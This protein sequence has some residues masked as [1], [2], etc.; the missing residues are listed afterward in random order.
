MS[1]RMVLGWVLVVLWGT[2]VRA[3]VPISRDLLPTRTALARVGLERH[4]MGMVPMEPT[5]RLLEISIADNLLFAQTDHANFYTFDAESGRLL[6][7]ARLGRQSGDAM[8]A[9]VNSRMVFVTNANLLYALDRATGRPV[10]VENLNL[11]ATSPTAC[12]EERVIVGLSTG[13]LRAFS[14]YE[15]D[16]KGLLVKDRAGRPVTA[17]QATFAWNWQTIGTMRSRP[18]PAGRLVVFGGHD[19]RAY[20][21]LADQAT[22]VYR[23]ATGGEI[24]APIS[25]YKT[26]TFLIPSAD[27]NVYSIDLFTAQVNWVFSTGA[28]V[29]QEPLVVDNDAYIV[30]AA[31]V[32]FAMDIPTGKSRWSTT[33]HG[34]RLVSVSGTRIYLETQD[35][36]LFIVDRGTGKMLADP[37]TTYTRAGLNLRPFEVE[38]TNSLNDRIYLGT[39]GGLVLG[40]REIGQL[41]PRPLRDPKGPPF[42]YIPPEG[43]SIEAPG[44]ISPTL[45]ATGE[46]PAEPAP[47]TE[48]APGAEN[49]PRE[50][51]PNP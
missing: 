35:G 37:R 31:G 4:W 10:W 7:M 40:L 17:H 49:P 24:F 20:V 16:E 6:W 28:P 22:M 21:A 14:L 42:G 43:L 9:S 5:E 39:K 34:G 50:P 30:N 13:L 36:D 15:R 18:L 1:R 19:G 29:M 11:L 32:L 27:R 51:Q 41:Q 47:G 26:R 8:P 46:P 33:T 12:D 44:A 23:I 48:P 2:S 38:L 3:Q 45:P 25:P